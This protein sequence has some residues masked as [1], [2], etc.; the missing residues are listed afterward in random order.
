MVYCLYYY[1]TPLFWKENYFTSHNYNIY[2]ILKKPLDLDTFWTEQKFKVHRFT[3]RK[4]RHHII[5]CITLWGNIKKISNSQCIKNNTNRFI[6]NTC[7]DTTKRE[8]LWVFALV[9]TRLQWPIEPKFSLI[10]YF[11]I[12]CDTQSVGLWTVLFVDVVRLLL[13]NIY[14]WFTSVMTC[15]PTLLHIHTCYQLAIIQLAWCRQLLQ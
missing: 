7:H 6:L 1:Y 8:D 3:N 5:Q 2:T 9:F 4:N 15:P 13:K 12:S 14:T 10:C 11:I